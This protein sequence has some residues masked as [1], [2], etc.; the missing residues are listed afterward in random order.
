MFLIYTH[1]FKKSRCNFYY[2]KSIYFNGG[3]LVSPPGDVRTEED[4]QFYLILKRNKLKYLDSLHGFN[5]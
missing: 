2:S 3:F 4:K 1:L 5:L